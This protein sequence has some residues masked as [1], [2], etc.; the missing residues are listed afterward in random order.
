[1]IKQQN[2]SEE[3]SEPEV[4]SPGLNTSP[5]SQSSSDRFVVVNVAGQQRIVDM[6]LIEDY[7]K[8]LTHGG[9]TTLNFSIFRVSFGTSILFSNKNPAGTRRPRD[10]VMA[11][12]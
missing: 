9:K 10:V 5:Q 2:S 11:S 7:L 12:F 4:R 8:V 6:K 1:M 3:G